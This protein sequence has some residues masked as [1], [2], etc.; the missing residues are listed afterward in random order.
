MTERTG[1]RAAKAKPQKSPPAG[2]S[3][4]PLSSLQFGHTDDAVGVNARVV[5][6]DQ[7]LDEL[8]ASILAHGLIQPLMV[9]PDAGASFTVVAGNRRLAALRQLVEAGKLADADPQ[10]SVVVRDLQDGEALEISLAE[11]L[12]RL[13][14]HP[15]DQF[16]VFARLGTGPDAISE[17]AIAT[18]FGI[19]RKEV[20]QRLALGRL[21]PEILAAWRS[22]E[23]RAESAQAFTLARDM[24]HQ[25]E[26][27][28]KLQEG[29]QLHSYHI[30]TAFSQNV[31]RADSRFV[32]FVGLDTY[33]AAGGTVRA[34][35]FSDRQDL[36]RPDILHRL[37]QQKIET[38]A[39]QL[40]AEGWSWVSLRDDLAQDHY[41][42][43]R[44]R[45]ADLQFTAEEEAE[46][47][48]IQE[49]QE[50]QDCHGAEY[51]RL[52]Q[53]ARTIESGAEARAF[54]PEEL[55]RAGAI[56]NIGY[57]GEV[58]VT[59]GV[60]APGAAP[61][62][63]TPAAEEAEAGPKPISAA[64]A[65]GLSEQLSNA[66]AAGLA[67]DRDLALSVVLA[68][69]LTSLGSPCIVR[70]NGR[71]AGPL[72]ER[73]G[74]LRMGRFA[75]VLQTLSAMPTPHRLEVLAAV[76]GA[77]IDASLSA[78]GGNTASAKGVDMR[79]VD[80]IIGS[81]DADEMRQQLAGQF[82]AEAYFTAATKAHAIAALV[83]IH[84]RNTCISPKKG[85]IAGLAAIEAKKHGWLPPELRTVHY[86]GPGALKPK[87]KKTT[88][89][90]A[91]AEPALQ[92]AE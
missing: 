55:S 52:T 87:A 32:K 26:V 47:A 70:H 63:A 33:T 3:M 81:I 64:L 11:N 79:A 90:K 25:R 76:A 69:F 67:T 50:E 41:S 73:I 21:A 60:V 5:D 84:G 66:I 49:R 19:E 65:Q 40:R 45:P 68:S 1:A 91:V 39:E 24:D 83:E 86:D 15:V 2:T 7:G 82:D 43:E 16:E 54:T 35:L 58:G 51:T 57:D 88:R 56:V 72:E 61:L 9:R 75:D 12:A 28:G 53:R 78:R 4:V 8:A 18:R 6:R 31:E 30:Q 42:W 27:F 36:T 92:A 44:L 20:R 13:P 80:A 17:E 34:D 14:L 29:G 38:I 46:L 37:V 10:V 59:R 48:R 22:G 85:D 77:A 74:D 89:R 71:G 62:A 23:I